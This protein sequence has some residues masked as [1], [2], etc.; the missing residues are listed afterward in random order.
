[1]DHNAYAC[2]VCIAFEFAIPLG[3]PG[4]TAREAAQVLEEWDGLKTSEAV[5]M[6][7]AH[8]WRELR[9]PISER[10]EGSRWAFPDEELA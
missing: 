8:G 7:M 2:Q 10:E 1:M 9:H 6:L 5:R 3:K 4:I